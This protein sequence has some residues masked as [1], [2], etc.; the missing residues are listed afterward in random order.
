MDDGYKVELTASTFNDGYQVQ[1]ITLD[2]EEF[3]RVEAALEHQ[4]TD[5]SNKEHVGGN[6]YMQSVITR[7]GQ[8]V[9]LYRGTN[10]GASLTER[11]MFCQV[12]LSVEH[13][14]WMK[15][16]FSKINTLFLIINDYTSCKN[17]HNSQVTA[18]R[19]FNCMGP[20]KKWD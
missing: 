8:T 13:W 20:E 16:V 18:M 2:L 19:C 6:L 3:K 1:C 9:I 11:G 12:F 10:I 14:A 7:W 15:K 17:L 4:P 5:I